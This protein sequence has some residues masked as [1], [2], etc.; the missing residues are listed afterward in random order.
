MQ[1][2]TPAEIRML[3]AIG[4]DSGGMS[5]V[6]KAIQARALGM[7]VEGVSRLTNWAA[8]LSPAV[9]SHDDVSTVGNES[10]GQLVEVLL[11]AF[12]QI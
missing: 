6:P 10:A 9:L 8:G 12:P 4:A 2:E 3:R 7:E 5:T 1:F 11:R